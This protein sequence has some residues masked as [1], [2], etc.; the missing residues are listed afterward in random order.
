[1]D[2][3]SVDIAAALQARLQQA[4]LHHLSHL[5]ARY[6]AERLC[7]S[8]G[9]AL[10]ARVNRAILESG[11]FDEVFIQPA[12]ADDGASLGAA[13]W[14][15]HDRCP[16]DGRRPIDH[17]F[18]G[19]EY[20]S[21]EIEAC[22]RRSEAVVWSREDRIEATAARLL[23]EGKVIGWFQGRMEMGPRALGGR[24]ILA[25]PRSAEVRDRINKMVKRREPFRPFA[26]SVLEDQAGEFFQ[27][28]N[29]RA[30]PYMLVT[31]E[32]LAHRRALIP[33]VV[34]V[35]GS[36]RIQ[37]VSA[38]VNPRYHDL[39]QRFFKETGVP[40]LLNTSFNQAGEPIVNSPDDAVS[41]FLR[42]GLDALAVGDYLVRPG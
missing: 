40:V 15:H 42:S 20:T 8:G 7:I 18:W 12:A 34:H 28:A 2:R 31:F 21:T 41:C 38:E 27:L 11:L 9:V 36:A 1:M 26:P 17:V 33:A 24:S 5:R 13:L 32:T 19:P 22:L 6:P 29:T 3:R 23:A 16:S 39:L 37:T 30:A 10:N 35:D 14:A 4:V 25:D